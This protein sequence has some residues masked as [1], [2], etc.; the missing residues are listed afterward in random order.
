MLAVVVV[1][2]CM[3]GPMWAVSHLTAHEPSHAG[4]AATSA[5]A[6]LGAIFR[7]SARNL[8]RSTL[9][10]AVRATSRAVSRRVA[11]ALLR[12]L[13]GVFLPTLD[14]DA[15]AER[16]A[17][18]PGWI[19]ISLGY[20]AL[21]LSFGGVLYFSGPETR[22]ALCG[23]TSPVVLALLAGAPLLAHAAMMQ[24]WAPRSGV[25]VTFSTTLDG[26]LLQAYF[27]GAMSFLPLSSD[28]ELEGPSR[29]K[30]LCSA[31]VLLGM[32]GLHV[33]F[34]L[35][36]QATGLLALQQL[37]SIFLVYCFVFSFPLKPLDGGDIWAENRWGWL[38]VWGIVLFF[39]LGSLPETFYDI[40]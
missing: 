2:V 29:G 3:I 12:S 21:V 4:V 5:A 25:T 22:A 28:A 32:V 23:T 8:L 18:L 24:F 11:R 38:F 13:M 36:G 30:A 27:T 6:A 35:I 37:A 19:A 40:L 31:A 39:F 7:A 26:L 14:Q 15:L 10:T 1:G 9:M 16:R 33:A 34:A 20:V 17:P